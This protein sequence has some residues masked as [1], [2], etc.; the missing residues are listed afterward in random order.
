MVLQITYL[1]MMSSFGALRGSTLSI[2]IVSLLSAVG[3]ILWR[4]LR[5]Y[6][7]VTLAETA[8]DTGQAAA[9]VR[10]QLTSLPITS[11]GA[12]ADL[13]QPPS[14]GIERSTVV[15]VDSNSGL[16]VQIDSGTN[17]TR[18]PT[19]PSYASDADTHAD[20][21]AGTHADAADVELQEVP[22]L[23]PEMSGAARASPAM[24]SAILVHSE[25]RGDEHEV[26]EEGEGG[27]EGGA[28]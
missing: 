1:I 27:D 2:S 14:Q 18:L 3:S 12:A 8:T 7:I 17:A 6:I 20:T 10:F 9:D 22:Q 19:L 23:A 15:Q 26:D 24:A 4:G 16:A 13:P 21:H 25:L 28:K 11:A 5:K